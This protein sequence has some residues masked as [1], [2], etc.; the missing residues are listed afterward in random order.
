LSPGKSEERRA[1]VKE[2]KH[3][4]E[5]MSQIWDIKSLA[6][7]EKAQQMF[8]ATILFIVVLQYSIHCKTQY[9]KRR[10]LGVLIYKSGF[11]PTNL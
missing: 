9:H 1:D 11:Q 3:K 5:L 10:N 4:L 8:L 6:F 7:Q 2:T